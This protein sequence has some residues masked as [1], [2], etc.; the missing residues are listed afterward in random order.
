MI[1]VTYLSDY[2]EGFMYFDTYAQ[3]LAWIDERSSDGSIDAVR[4]F[5]VERELTA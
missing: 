3:A 2:G 1:V 4:V 5:R